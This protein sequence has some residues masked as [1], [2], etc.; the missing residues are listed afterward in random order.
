MSYKTIKISEDFH[1]ELKKHC[2]ERNLKLNAFCEMLIQSGF[3]YEK[4]YNLSHPQL[5][6]GITKER[7]I[8]LNR[9][10]NLPPE[11]IG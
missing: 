8:E 5:E 7:L 3:L 1:T 2:D 6:K 9:I 10:N 11:K 4:E